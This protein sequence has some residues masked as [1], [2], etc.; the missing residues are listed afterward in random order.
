MKVLK[1]FEGGEESRSQE[2]RKLKEK[3]FYGDDIL[4]VFDKCGLVDKGR[5]FLILGFMFRN[6]VYVALLLWL[7]CLVVRCCFEIGD[8]KLITTMI[9]EVVPV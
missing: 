4:F 8:N 6:H 2:R 5:F 9:F 3:A 1:E 7:Q